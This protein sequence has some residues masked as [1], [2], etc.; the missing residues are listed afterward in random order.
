[1][2]GGYN[3]AGGLDNSSG[4]GGGAGGGAVRLTAG[5]KVAISSTGQ[6]STNGGDGGSRTLANPSTGAGAG[7]GGSGGALIILAGETITNNGTLSAQRGSAGTG[8]NGGNGGNG[9]AGR[10]RFED[11]SGSG[12][13]GSGTET[14][15]QQSAT[16]G[17]SFYSTSSYTVESNS[18]DSGSDSPVYT[19]FTSDATVPSGSTASYQI[20]GSSD[21]FVS[22]DTGFV[23]TN[24]LSQIDGKR[25]FK[26]KVTLQSGDRT[27]TP[28]VRSIS[29]G[30]FLNSFDFA[31]PACARIHAAANTTDPL[32]VGL[33]LLYFC[34]LL[35]LPRQFAK[36]IILNTTR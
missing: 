27:E 11:N 4:G 26:F 13:S 28:E 8:G 1:V 19:F 6:I 29:I 17:K 12:L 9:G 10:T 34:L 16:I 36:L 22:D 15:G 33:S 30:V 24:Q 32:S 14:P 25:Y 3:L 21:D 35:W 20:A 7:G 2:G 23:N 5:G 18:Y 31:I